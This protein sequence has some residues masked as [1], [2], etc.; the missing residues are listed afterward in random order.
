MELQHVAEREFTREGLLAAARSL[1]SE[2]AIEVQ[3]D[4]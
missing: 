1:A 3:F 2:W 4:E